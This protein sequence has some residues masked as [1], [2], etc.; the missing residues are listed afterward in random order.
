MGARSELST[1][2]AVLARNRVLFVAA[3]LT[4]L[5]GSASSVVQFASPARFAPFLS[6]ALSAVLVFVS[7]FLGGGLFGMANE[8]LSGR[9]SMGTFWKEGKAK[10]LRLLGG[11]LLLA[12]M[13]VGVYVVLVIV[14]IVF[15]LVFGAAQIGADGINGLGPL[16]LVLAVGFGVL[17]LLVVLA[18][19][20]VF[21]FYGPAVVV[22]DG[23]LVASFT[24]SYRLVR[25]NLGSVLGFDAVVVGVS[26]LSALPT[27]GLFAAQFQPFQPGMGPFSLFAGVS[28]SLIAGYFVASLV[29][30]VPVTAFTATYQ[31]AFFAGMADEF[32]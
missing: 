15:L 12:A 7:P 25:D 21:Q 8:G 3:T 26:I 4:W 32:A 31:I 20:F 28:P 23:T 27:I 6:L 29:L 14:A 5:V 9:T 30:G 17:A 1:A 22:T 18:P 19:L 10:Y 13:L 24:H 2:I 16:F 11:R